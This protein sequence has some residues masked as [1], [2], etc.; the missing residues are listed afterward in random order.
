MDNRDYLSTENCWWA[1]LR[2][3]SSFQPKTTTVIV[4]KTKEEVVQVK[5][6]REKEKKKKRRNKKLK[7]SLVLGGSLKPYKTVC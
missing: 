3:I 2:V 4:T 1:I 5:T 7:A 6:Y